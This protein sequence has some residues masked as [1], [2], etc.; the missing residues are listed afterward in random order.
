MAEPLL[1][2]SPR[3]LT[4]DEYLSLFPTE[5]KGADG[6]SR[7]DRAL[8]CALDIRKFEIDLY[9]KRAGYFWAFIG[10]SFA[11]YGATASIKDLPQRSHLSVAV[12]VLGFVF[13]VGWFCVNSGSKWWQ[14]NWEN[15]VDLLEDDSMGPLYKSVFGPTGEAGAE[16]IMR[17]IG[18]VL[19]RPRD[20]SV[21][22]INLY[23]SSII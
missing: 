9:W 12:G 3:A 20:F 2:R 5:P 21:S 8:E 1:R 10:A 13:S 16:H 4:Q 15:H 7:R 17:R 6:K 23:V 11:A 14:E 18:R 19:T 22:K